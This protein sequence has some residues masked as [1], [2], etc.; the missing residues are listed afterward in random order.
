MCRRP[1]LRTS[2]PPEWSR[3]S[4][5]MG[6][7]PSPF[8]SAPRRLNGEPIADAVN[9]EEMLRFVAVVAELLAQLDDDLVEG[10]SGAVIVVAPDL[11]EQAIPRQHLAGMSI[12]ELQQ[13]QLLGS[14]F[15]D[16]LAAFQLEGL[17]INGGGA[18]LERG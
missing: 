11:V 1:R 4:R 14:E 17:G 8:P 3:V 2:E 15:F 16:R 7:T 12:E 9:G 13:L 10:A 5:G 6:V 18:N